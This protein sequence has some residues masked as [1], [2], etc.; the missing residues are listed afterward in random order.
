MKTFEEVKIY[1]ESFTFRLYDAERIMGFLLGKGLVEK[2]E[3]VV[4]GARKG[5]KPLATFEDFYSWFEDDD[6]RLEDLMNF[7][8]D[9]QDKAIEKGD[10]DKAN[11][12]ASYRGFLVDELELEYDEIVEF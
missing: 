3:K 11:K 9:E 8:Q 5:Y 1:L 2:G 6:T 10:F 12:L 7:L 4:F